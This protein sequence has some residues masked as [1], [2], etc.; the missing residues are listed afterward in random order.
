MADPPATPYSLGALYD[1]LRPKD[2]RAAGQYR[3]LGRL[4]MGGMGEIFLGQ[5]RSGFLVAVKMARPELLSE[6]DFRERFAREAAAAKRVS[7]AFTAP[8]VDADARAEVPWLATQYVPAPSLDLLV[9]RA[10]PLPV[11]AVRWLAAGIAEALVSIH[12]EGLV[13]RDL[14]PTNVLVTR[15]NPKVI[16]FGLVFESD[17][18]SR[19]T[20]E[21]I[22]TPAFMP[23]EQAFDMSSVTGASDMYSLG[24][25]LLFAA[26][27]HAPYGGTTPVNVV[28]RLLSEAPD[29]SGLP[30][31]LEDVIRACIDRN[32]AARPTPGDLL[33]IFGR[34]WQPGSDQFGAEHWLPPAAFAVVADFERHRPGGGRGTVPADATPVMPGKARVS[35]RKLLTVGGSLA[36]AVAASGGVW[37]AFGARGGGAGPWSFAT[38]AEVYSSP[39]VVKGTLYI[40]SSDGHLYALDAATGAKR[41]SYPAGDSI[42]SSPAVANGVVY[43]GCNNRRLHAVDARTGKARWTFPARAV[44]HSSPTVADGVVYVGCRDRHLYAIDAATGRERWRFTGG[45]WFNSS[46]RVANGAVFVGCRDKNVY[47]V[48]AA[49]GR[50]RWRFTT[51]STVDSS[52]A[53]VGDTVWIGGDDYRVYALNAATGGQIWQFSAG[54]GVV[55]SPRVVDDV[56][57]VGSDDGNLYALDSTTGR[58]RWRVATG[59]QIRSSPVVAGGLVYVGS[60]DRYLYAVD[61]VTGERRWRYAT[62]GPIDDSSPTV[63]GGLVYVGSLDGHIYAIDAATGTGP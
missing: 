15:D 30:P 45:D 24:A 57:Y 11:R 42:T 13:H 35:R 29:L 43:V 41:W 1:P 8:V 56:V 19:I 58:E 26:T 9:R 20:Q 7:G 49:T 44:I 23:P 60:R 34:A 52:P 25:T 38:G 33:D 55:S 47:A 63:V 48:E 5:S 54:R 32:P 51:G 22:G 18:T 10:G 27:T 6:P 40:G 50:E 53:I 37:W 62:K 61:T 46:P 2:P 4:G 17:A 21:L 12:R 39:A 3:I 16:D 14:K 28:A 36:A 31:E 59:N